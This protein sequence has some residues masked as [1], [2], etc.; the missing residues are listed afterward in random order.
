MLKRLI[1]RIGRRGSVLLFLAL[2]DFL[3]GYS[4]LVAPSPVV[5][6]ADA[7]FSLTTWGIA[8]LTVGTV[9]LVEAFLRVDRLAFTLAVLIKFLWGTTM[10][11]SWWFTSTNP[12]G[13]ISATIFLSF[14][15]LTAII[16]FWPEQRYLDIK[17]I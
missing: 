16:S 1:Y 10:L 2:L 15:I 14:G 7:F 4:L 11:L 8:W 12:H 3:Y 17:E 5:V 9:C 13:W 6:H